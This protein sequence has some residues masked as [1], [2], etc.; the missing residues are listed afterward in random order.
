MNEVRVL[1]DQVAKTDAS[2]LILGESGTGKEQVARAIHERGTARLGPFVAINCAA[3]PENLMESELFGHEKGAFTGASHAKVGL[4]EAANGGTILLD[5]IGDMPMSLQPKLLRVL[6]EQRIRRV[7]ANQ[8]REIKVRVIAATHQNLSALVKQ[9]RFRQ[10]LL[11]RLDVMTLTLPALR[12]RLED[13]PELT[14]YFLQKFSKEHQK[15]ILGIDSKAQALLLEHDWPGNIREL[16]N[17]LERAVV[18]NSSGSILRDDLPPHIGA[19]AELTTR[20]D[21]ITIPLGMSLKQIEEL[22]IKVALERTNGDRAEA[23][24][25][26]GMAERTIY[27]KI[28]KTREE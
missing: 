16:S 13:V 18:L 11:Y 27:R 5:E 20:G 15:G 19:S 7:G 12:D 25:M 8:E 3:I 9:Q 2:V 4:F 23:A 22:M 14:Q 26:L 28:S 17:V 6:E 10:D 24:R 21:Q 1:I